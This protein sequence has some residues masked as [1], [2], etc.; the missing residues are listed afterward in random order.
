[1]NLATVY[2]SAFTVRY[3]LTRLPTAM[4]SASS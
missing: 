3:D 2:C 4:I 1:M